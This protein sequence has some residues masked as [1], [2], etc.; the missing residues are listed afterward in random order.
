[1]STAAIRVRPDDLD[2]LWARTEPDLELD[3]D[4]RIRLIPSESAPSRGS[5]L[6]AAAPLAL[7]AIVS[8]VARWD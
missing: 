1:V 5:V 8:S 4:G 7:G 2:A 6:G 3:Q